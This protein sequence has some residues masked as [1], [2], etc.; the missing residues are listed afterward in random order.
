MKLYN[1]FLLLFFVY[2][3]IIIEA[4][5]IKV[6]SAQQIT[7]K[8]EGIFYFPKFSPDGKKVF[9]TSAN[10]I[11]IYY[12]DITHGLLKKLNNSYGSGYGFSFSPDSKRIYYREDKFKGNKKISSIVVQDIST[13]KIIYLEKDKTGL[14]VPIVTSAG[15][16]FYTESGKVNILSTLNKTLPKSLIKKMEPVVYIENENLMIFINGEKKILDPLGSGSY[17]WP[18]LS[19]DKKKI[20]FT[21]A[22]DASYI[23]DLN[24]KVLLNL[25][26]ANAP[27]WSPDGKWITYMDDRSDG[28]N[29]KS[30]DIM[31]MLADGKGKSELTPENEIIKLYPEWSPSG[32]KIVYHSLDGIIY[33]LKLSFSE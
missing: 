18:S 4:Q 21:F 26:W 2:I 28:Y 31:A 20:L 16:C 25:G 9:F 22:G 23:C 12:Y 17:L 7:N 30:S 15:D 8:N 29:F 3:S 6:I 1:I 10:F 24:G 13:K 19:P 33:L 27:E 32:D 11:G 5:N 14:S